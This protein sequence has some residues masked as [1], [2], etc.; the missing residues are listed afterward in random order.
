MCSG[1]SNVEVE[2]SYRIEPMS[3]GPDSTGVFG[4]SVTHQIQF[5]QLEIPWIHINCFGGSFTSHFGDVQT[6]SVTLFSI[7]GDGTGS[8]GW[9]EWFFQ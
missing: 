2:T 4:T 1:T 7:V 5:R 9:T 6:S 3:V 8:T